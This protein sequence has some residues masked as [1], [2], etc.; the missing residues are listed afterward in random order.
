MYEDYLE[1]H[2]V[3][4]QK[5]GVRRYQNP[6]GT[7]T[8]AGKRRY[9]EGNLSKSYQ[10]RLNDLDTAMSM[11]KKDAIKALNRH[12]KLLVRQNKSLGTRIKESMQDPFWEPSPITKRGIQKQITKEWYK[13]RNASAN[14][15]AGKKE[16]NEILRNMVKNNMYVSSKPVSKAAI[17][18][19]KYCETVLAN[20]MPSSE[21]Y[22]TGDDETG[23]Y[24]V[25]VVGSK[26]KVSERKKFGYKNP[27]E[28]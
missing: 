16:T 20:S 10:N 24:R 9:Q 27:S 23:K 19:R 15:E 8:D 4:G 22:V 25:D 11:H 17:K 13:I 28:M 14:V 3:L 18:G 21:Y 12:D 26:Y 7:L 6:D 1:H 2:G 5:W